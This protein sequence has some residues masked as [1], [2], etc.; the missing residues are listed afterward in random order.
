M[1]EKW[2]THTTKPICEHEDVT[3][4]QTPGVHTDRAVM[5]NRPDVIN[6]HKNGKNMRNERLA[7]PDNR[8]VT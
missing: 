4:L 6:K 1:T 8:N 2:Y 5:T 3:V 7:T